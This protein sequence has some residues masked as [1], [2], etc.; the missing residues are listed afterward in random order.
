MRDFSKDLKEG[1]KGAA[2]GKSAEEEWSSQR[3]LPRQSGQLR[4][5]PCSGVPLK[6]PCD[7]RGVALIYL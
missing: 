6:G 1:V 3:Q 7:T 5:A 2:G 4:A